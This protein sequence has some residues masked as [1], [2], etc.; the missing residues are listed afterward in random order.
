MTRGRSVREAEMTGAEMTGADMAWGRDGLGSK[1]LGAEMV[2]GRSICKSFQGINFAATLSLP[3][4][5][6]LRWCG[7]HILPT[8]LFI[9]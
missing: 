6:L 8:I 5:L 3:N 4:A 2:W 7:L 9:T 1:C